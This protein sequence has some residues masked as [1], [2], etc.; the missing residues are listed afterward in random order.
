MFRITKAGANR[1]DI[2]FGG[3]LDADEMRQAIDEL[4][5]KSEGMENW[6]VDSLNSVLRVVLAWSAA[7][8]S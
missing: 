8:A 4:V 1:L 6:P 3:K 2:E 7:L 5:S